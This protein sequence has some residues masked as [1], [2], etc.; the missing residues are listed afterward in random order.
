MSLRLRLLL[1]AVAYATVLAMGGIATTVAISTWSDRL[2]D[3]RS[4]LLAGERVARLESAFLDQETG[5]RG[6][7]ITGNAAFLEPYERGKNDAVTLVDEIRRLVDADAH[8]VGLL[9]AVEA[10]AAT[11]RDDAA[12]PEIAARRDEGA[13]AAQAMIEDGTGKVLFD[14]ARAASD[15]LA[16]HVDAEA[17]RQNDAAEE[18]REVAIGVL[19]A[20]LLILVLLTGGVA[21]LLR[22][23]VMRPLDAI[24]L[25]ARRIRHGDNVRVPQ[26]G[27]PELRDVAASVDDMQSTIRHQRDAAVIAREAIEQHAVLALQLRNE[28]TS[29]VGEVPDGWEVAA[30]MRAAEGVVAGDS[31]DVSLLGPHR[32][33]VVLLDIAGHGALAAM[34]A[35]K[36]KELLR[37]AMRNDRQ[38][39]EALQ[40]VF[41]QDLGLGDAF[42]T[43]F[44]AVVDTDTGVMRYANAGHP[45]AMHATPDGEVDLLAPTGP[46]VGP[47]TP[48]WSTRSVQMQA[49]STVVAYT[50][51]ITESRDADRQFYGEGRLAEQIVTAAGGGAVAMVDKLLEDLSAFTPGRF[52]DDVTVVAICRH[53]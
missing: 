4:F 25:A 39:G 11:W 40:W 35:F 50:D 26:S 37:V 41:D 3:R 8:T 38:P 12:E 17:N 28:L 34:N 27:P 7:V 52:V 1:V 21:L 10:D 48:G 36:C 33:G 29:E 13:A 20:T 43:A 23:W 16:A 44:V 30:G 9:D 19:V 15:V 22:R 32:I 6:Y 47:I 53:V 45:P 18:A 46:L 14:R 49:G 24:G 31:Y 42:F 5:Q 2:D 51:G